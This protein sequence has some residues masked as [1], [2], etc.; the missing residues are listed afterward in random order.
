[1]LDAVGIGELA[2]ELAEVSQQFSGRW[3]ERTLRYTTTKPVVSL[4]VLQQ[5]KG[6]YIE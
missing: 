4:P 6:R 2:E 1:M 5:P 3:L